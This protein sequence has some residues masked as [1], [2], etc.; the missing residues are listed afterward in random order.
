[1]PNPKEKT[2]INKDEETNP[3]VVDVEMDR[4]MPDQ[5]GSNGRGSRG[6]KN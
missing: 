2:A 6:S 1:M 4:F 5:H 3:L